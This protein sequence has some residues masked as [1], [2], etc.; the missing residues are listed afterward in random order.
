ME[1]PD[2]RDAEAAQ[3]GRH[4]FPDT[5][6]PL[7]LQRSEEARLVAGGNHDQAIRLLELRRDLGH[8]P[9]GGEPG[10]GGE[11]CSLDDARLDPTHG[12]ERAAVQAIGPGEVDERLV[13]RDRLDER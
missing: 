12:L 11:A 3:L 5:P 6:D 2:G 8:E 10:R 4:H 1:L 13:H 7:D 9:V